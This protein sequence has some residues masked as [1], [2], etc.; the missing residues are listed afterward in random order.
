MGYIY[1]I[2]VFLLFVA[3][4]FTGRVGNAY[5]K[6]FDELPAL[7]NLSNKNLNYSTTFSCKD[8]ILSMCRQIGKAAWKS[9]D[10][11]VAFLVSQIE[12]NTA[13]LNGETG[14]AIVQARELYEKAKELKF[15]QGRALALQA[16]GDSYMHT[17]LYKLAAETFEE[18]ESELKKGDDN[19]IRLR[20]IIQQVYVYLKLDNLQKAMGCLNEAD[21]LLSQVNTG[22]KDF[23]LYILSYRAMAAIKMGNEKL[24]QHYWEETVKRQRENACSIG[25]FLDLSINYYTFTKELD[26][27][28]AYHD[29]LLNV[30]QSKGN[31]YEYKNA[32]QSKG[33]LMH[34]LGKVQEACELYQQVKELNRSLNTERFAEALDSI[35]SLY[36]ADR[37]DLE[38]AEAYWGLLIRIICFSIIILIVIEL[39]V[40]VIK[41]KNRALT[42]SRLRLSEANERAKQSILSKS[43]FLSNMTHEIRT[44]LNAIVGF[45]DV[46]SSMGD[47]IDD[48][49][50]QVCGESIRQNA[51]L[52][53]K[54]VGDV[55]ELTE[56]EESNMSFTMEKCEVVALCRH[57]IETVERVKRTSAQLSFNTSLTVLE[58][59]TD[60][61]RLQQVLI[62]L[63]INATKF[64]PSGSITLIL[65][66][67]TEKNEAVFTVEDT[68]CGIPLDRQN[69]IFSR[70]EKLHE[71]IQGSGIGLSICQF[72]VEKL[73]GRI[74]IDS[75]Y[76]AGARF[77][78]THPL[79]NNMHEV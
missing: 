48:E 33:T 64:T 5:A 1:R 12:V 49:T 31:S 30:S 9:K 76:T 7:I 41:R 17:G 47:T 35:R 68:G 78:F 28:I 53:H 66:L 37:M 40:V 70:F 74:W 58:L 56:V 54:L 22:K 36:I 14:R 72:I 18:A 25:L 65:A 15:Q 52:L 51:Q 77:I 24:A 38:N 32:L 6:S 26:K 75:G 59:Y 50:R 55:M 10:L 13:G 67:D 19:L 20:L 79:D 61:T 73:K 2:L 43:M 62:N 63:L 8:S 4:M 16:I 23:E 21:R 3:Y 27:A 44:P 57:V 11:K 46:L 45:S 39:M 60:S 71:G 34:S 42:K 69:A 29:S